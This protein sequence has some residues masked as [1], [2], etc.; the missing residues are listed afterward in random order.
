VN[1]ALS[2]FTRSLGYRFRNPDLALTALRHRSAGEPNNERLEFL[3]D[4]LLGYVIAEEL[5]RRFP[6]ADEGKLTRLRASLVKRETLATIA[7]SLD[8]G[9]YLELGE[10]ER[11]TGG[12]QRDSILANALEAII[13]AIYLDAGIDACRERLLAFYGTM[14]NEALFESVGKDPKTELQEYLQARHLNL[15]LYEVVATEGEPHEQVFTVKCTG[16][17]MDVTASGSSRRRAEQEAA[18]QILERL[19]TTI[20]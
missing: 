16:A 13:G 5:F 11:K 17:G 18:K 10:G 7:R 15:P 20:P 3:G 1:D 19:R 9:Q 2:R 6:Q 14:L 4:A 12:W 8:I